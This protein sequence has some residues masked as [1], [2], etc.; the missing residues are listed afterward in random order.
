MFALV[1]LAACGGGIPGNAVV[2]VDGNIDHQRHVQPLDGRGGGLERGGARAAKPVVPDPP[3][4]TACIA[5]P[6]RPRRNPPKAR[7]PPTEAQLK[8][9]CEQQYKSLQQEVLGFLI[10]SNWVIGEAKSLGVKVTDKEVKKQ[11]E[12]IKSQ[13]FPKA[14]EFEKFL[15]TSGQTVSDLLLRVKL[16][17]LSQKIQ[18]KIVK[19]EAESHPGARSR[20]TTTKTNTL[21]RA[22]K[23]QRC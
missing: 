4:Y 7:K 20:S 13:Q 22:G 6:K 15:T 8:S 18:Q 1:G 9:Q 12:K 5:H 17:L 11:F 23:A 3:N 10:S 2:A 19:A 14:A 16:N 21:R